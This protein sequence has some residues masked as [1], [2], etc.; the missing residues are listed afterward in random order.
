MISEV[1]TLGRKVL[2]ATDCRVNGLMSTVSESRR[3]EQY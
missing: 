3:S 2:Q 1:A